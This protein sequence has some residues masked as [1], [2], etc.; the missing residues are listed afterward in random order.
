M[1]LCWFD[2]IVSEALIGAICVQRLMQ[3]EPTLDNVRDVAVFIA[4]AVFLAPFLSSFLDSAFVRL[5]DWGTETYWQL[6]TT[7]FVSNVLATITLVPVI[8]TVA[9]LDW[10]A[11]RKL[12]LVRVAEAVGLAF[13]LV[14]A[15]LLVFDFDPAIAPS[16]PLYMTVPFLVWAALR[17]GP[18]GASASFAMI[19]FLT[20]WGAAHGRGPFTGGEPNENALTVQLFLTLVGMATL[21][22]AAFLKERDRAQ[23]ALRESEAHF[24]NIANTA[25]VM[26]WIIVAD[27]RF[28]FFNRRWLDLPAVARR[29]SRRERA[30]RCARRSG[31]RTTKRRRSGERASTSNTASATVPP[32][33]CSRSCHRRKPG[34]RPPFG[35]LD[36]R[37]DLL[38]HLEDAVQ[39]LAWNSDSRRRLTEHHDMVAMASS[40]R[41]RSCR[42][43]RVI[44]QDVVVQKI[45]EYLREARAKR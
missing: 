34:P 3:Q 25:P 22:L 9:R 12:A 37:I 36:R 18:L 42:R 23:A 32:C 43:Y 41:S 20:I 27:Q 4:C 28:T 6:W 33:I 11:L 16:V 26:I 31:R 21:T 29:R 14:V 38:E 8:V 45:G 1:M 2:N 17:F 24:R 7:R 35:A 39:F 44:L 15:G 19:A 5:N 30:E 13:A 10:P 40:P